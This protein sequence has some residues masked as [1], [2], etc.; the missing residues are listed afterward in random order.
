MMYLYFPDTPRTSD[1]AGEHSRDPGPLPDCRAC[2]LYRLPPLV[3][4]EYSLVG[5][6][7]RYRTDGSGLETLWRRQIFSS[8]HPSRPA[9]GPTQ[10]P[11]QLIPELFPGM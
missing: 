6:G 9:L 10:P 3:G 2:N 1:N 5:I 11:L 4:T 7:T 8:L